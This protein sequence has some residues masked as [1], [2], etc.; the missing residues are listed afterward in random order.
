VKRAF[1]IASLLSLLAFSG[2]RFT[3]AAQTAPP[4]HP[5]GIF[6]PTV[7]PVAPIDKTGRPMTI[8]VRQPEPRLAQS[9]LAGN[10]TGDSYV[11]HF[12]Q[13]D[14]GGPCIY[15]GTAR[16]LIEG[17]GELTLQ[18]LADCGKLRRGYS[19][20]ICRLDANLR[21]TEAPWW[22][23][24]DRTFI[25]TKEGVT[26]NGT[27]VVPWRDASE[28]PQLLQKMSEKIKALNERFSQLTSSNVMHGRS[29]SCREYHPET[30]SY[31][32]WEFPTTCVIKSVCDG[33]P[34]LDSLRDG[35][36]LDLNSPAG[37]FVRKQSKATNFSN[38]ICWIRTQ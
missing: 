6:T 25:I 7:S 26:V 33:M 11:I 29:I 1:H 30:K 13:G 37:T 24:R 15:S 18:V 5:D 14:A 10:P 36:Q 17:G 22:Y 4:S 32:V 9:M 38:W 35:E 8:E 21:C 3:A 27:T 23:F 2:A 12:P 34:N 19:Y 16:Y 31:H 20:M 28:V